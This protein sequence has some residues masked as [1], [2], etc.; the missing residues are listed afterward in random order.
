MHADTVPWSYVRGVCKVLH[1]EH[2]GDLEQCKR[3]KDTFYWCQVN[4]TH[5]HSLSL[6]LQTKGDSN[7]DSGFSF[8]EYETVV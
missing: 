6:L 2:V 3:E 5:T 8:G 7:T 4:L 1:K